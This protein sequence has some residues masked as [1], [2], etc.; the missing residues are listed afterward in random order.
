MSS[1]F[2][3]RNAVSSLISLFLA[4]ASILMLCAPF[5]FAGNSSRP[6]LAPS[7]SSATAQE[8]PHRADEVLVRFRADAS[9]V[10]R[11]T[12]LHTYGARR[13]KQ[14]R[15]DSRLEKLE[16]TEERDI[17]RRA[18]E[19]RLHPQVEFAEPNFLITKDDL[20]PSDPRFGEQWAL[21][22]TGQTG[23]QYGSNIS[24]GAAWQRTVGNRS[25]VIAVIDSGI[26]FT[27]PD[28]INNRWTNPSPDSTDDLHGWDYI[29][30][31]NE[32]KDEQGHGTAVAGIIAA[33]GDNATG[34][35]GVM[36][37]AGLMSLRVLD[38]TGTGDIADAVEAIDYA[39]TH[40]AHVIN[41]SWGTSGYSIFLKDAIERAVNSGVVVVCSAGNSNQDVET[42]PYY[43][44]S[45]AI[46]D[47]IA[48]ASTDHNDQADSV[49]ELGSQEC[50]CGR[51]GSRHSYHE[52]GW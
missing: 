50:N 19:L 49:V 39:V 26:D 12:I 13:K 46:K 30:N 27:H 8:A 18:L 25:T 22:N 32:I 28:L 9:E 10:D 16:F 6:P 35:I 51:A 1:V 45:F 36:W 42:T 37:R 40:G 34:T 14:L 41:L 2:F 4:Y 15:G 48:V 52:D 11:E 38:N 31:T 24:V 23:G 7:V 44:A 33:E 3:R 47:V 21:Q 29:T 43:P 20:T 5:A 17:Q